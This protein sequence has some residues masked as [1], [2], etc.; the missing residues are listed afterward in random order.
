MTRRNFLAYAGALSSASGLA[1]EGRNA[2]FSL[3]NIPGSLTPPD[4]FFVRDHFEEPEISLSAWTLKIEGSV[5]RPF[6][7]R[8]AD[9]L[10]S[11]THML[12]AV[13]E[14]AGNGPGGSAASNAVWEGVSIGSLLKRAAPAE[15][16]D[17]IILEGADAGRLGPQLP[18]LPYSQLIPIAKCQ[19]PESMVAFKLNDRFLPRKNG[20]PARALL[21][22]WYGMD[23]VKWLQRII[24]LA[25]GDPAAAD[26][27]A[28]GMDRL[29]NR[30]VVNAAGEIEKTRLA[31]IDVKSAIAWP[32]DTARL[33]AG[34]H[35]IRGFAW[36]AAGLVSSVRVTC[37]GGRSWT[38]AQFE[39]EPRHFAWT[40]WK[41]SWSA[42][43]GDY[44]L[45]ARASD[46]AGRQQPLQRDSSRKDGYAWNF[47]APIRC[48]VR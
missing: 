37:D 18:N 40:R 46:D 35:T 12:E 3:Q 8:F 5:A 36:T 39:S 6:S 26:F 13:L 22:G 24:V 38:P 7:L 21:P 17:T 10:E 11:Q 29:Y 48:S 1:S 43:P 23:S 19:S 14:C 32:P 45:M 20:F 15:D 25:P 41:F 34:T 4:L 27:H 16:A 28:S 47:C 2:S 42:K 44:V 31:D 30:E 9:L 33:P